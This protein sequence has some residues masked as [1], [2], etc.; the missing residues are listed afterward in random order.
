MSL[1]ALSRAILSAAFNH[2]SIC[3]FCS[4]GPVYSII[5]LGCHFQEHYL[6]E[7]NSSAQFLAKEG[8]YD[9]PFLCPIP[10]HLQNI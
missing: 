6:V 7:D 3:H 2:T 5:I 10:F 1:G 8:I 4:F 9:N